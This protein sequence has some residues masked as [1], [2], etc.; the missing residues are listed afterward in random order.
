MGNWS[1]SQRSI[2][3]TRQEGEE[4]TKLKRVPNRLPV[5]SRGVHLPGVVLLFTYPRLDHPLM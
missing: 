1:A 2:I 3:T 5:S 4:D